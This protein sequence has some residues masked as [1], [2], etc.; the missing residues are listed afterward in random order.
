MAVWWLN[1]M[2]AAIMVALIG[3]IS[4]GLIYYFARQWFGKIPA[5]IAAFLYAISPVNIIY[6]RSS[7]NPNPAPLFALQSGVPG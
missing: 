3:T 2:A 5:F 4:V 6:S 1:P 7:W